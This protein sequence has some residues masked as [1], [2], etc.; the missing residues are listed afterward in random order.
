MSD[1]PG[2][3]LTSTDPHSNETHADGKGHL[4][5]EG[6]V[7]LLWREAGLIAEEMAQVKLYIESLGECAEAAE[8]WFHEQGEKE[9]TTFLE[10]IA[11]LKAKFP[12]GDAPT[13]DEAPT[14]AAPQADLP[15]DASPSSEPPATSSPT[16]P[17][18]SAPESPSADAPAV[19]ASAPSPAP[20]TPPAEAPASEPPA[21]DAPADAGSTTPAP[22]AQ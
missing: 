5:G 7:R 8:D 20:E 12:L 6:I 22:A 10:L 19:E 18:E 15:G 16:P 21:T 17:L 1:A 2:R 13:P 14:G 4:V 11:E 9:V 3:D